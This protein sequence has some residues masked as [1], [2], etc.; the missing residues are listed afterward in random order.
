MAPP[1][2]MVLARTISA[3]CLG[4]SKRPQF[5]RPPR[6]RDGTAKLYSERNTFFKYLFCFFSAMTGSFHISPTR[7][8]EQGS[9]RVATMQNTLPKNIT[10]AAVKKATR[11][12]IS[13]Y[14]ARRQVYRQERELQFQLFCYGGSPESFRFWSTQTEPSS[15]TALATCT[16]YAERRFVDFQNISHPMGGHVF[17]F[18]FVL[19]FEV[20][21]S[22]LLYCFAPTPAFF[23]RSF[24]AASG[25]LWLLLSI[26]VSQK[27]SL[28]LSNSAWNRNMSLSDY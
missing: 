11:A 13:W 16:H 6:I 10:T 1:K 28:A 3:P 4:F 2:T 14:H 7:R 23:G 25:L 24:G 21:T 12:M 26:I 19:G 9:K 15:R 17:T 22:L 5:H 27:P 18:L 8:S 20:F